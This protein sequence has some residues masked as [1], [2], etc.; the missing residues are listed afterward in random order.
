[1]GQHRLGPHVVGQRVVLRHLVPGE[2]GPSG[3]PAMS[4][5]LG[6]CEEWGPT[7]VVIAREGGPRATVPIEDIVSGK[8]VPPRP[9]V[10]LRMSPLEAQ[11][12]SLVMWPGMR[13]EQVGDWVLR[14]A[15]D[16]VRRANSALAMG[17][18]QMSFSSAVERVMKF[19]AEVGRRPV[20]MV[21]ADDVLADRFADAGWVLD[22]EEPDVWFQVASVARA[23]RAVGDMRRIETE[24][25]EDGARMEARVGDVALARAAYDRDWLGLHALNVDPARRRQ[26]LALNLVATMLEW[27]AERGATTAY[28][29][30]RSDNEGAIQLYQRL[31]FATHHAY[32]YLTPGE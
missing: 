2:A 17:D 6:T 8:P 10:R 14:S 24:V 30:V 5:V 19:Y 21:D 11:L 3:G 32:R 28:L 18:P 29:Q 9:S 1:M 12:R 7:H 15:D 27:G 13:T 22:R 4:D 16:D 23:L 25:V 26:G 20:V 31:G